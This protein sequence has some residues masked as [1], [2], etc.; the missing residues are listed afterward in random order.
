MLQM[1]KQT[2]GR[3]ILLAGGAGTGKTT[4]MVNL[5]ADRLRRG[6]PGLAILDLEDGAAFYDVPRY[7]PVEDWAGVMAALTDF[8]TREEFDTLVFDTFDA[9]ARLIYSKVLKANGWS[10][11]QAN[12]YARWVP[13]AVEAVREFLATLERMQ[14]AYGNHFFFVSHVEPKAFRVPDADAGDYQK[15]FLQTQT[16]I[17]NLLMQWCDAVLLAKFENLTIQ[18][19]GR[20]KGVTTG[21]RILQTQYQAVFDG[22]NRFG[23]PPIM[24]LDMAEV[25]RICESDGDGELMKALEKEA[26]EKRDTVLAWVA[27]QPDRQAAVQAALGRLG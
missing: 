16:K 13:I 21:K 11:K 12:E 8:E 24:A 20:T 10:D 22:K 23:L 3:R 2:R 18:K 26:P 17:A 4:A 5:H 19:D 9:L 15:Y 1:G 25:E 7:P 14:R 6:R 27:E